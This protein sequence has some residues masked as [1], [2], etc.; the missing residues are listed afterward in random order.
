MVVAHRPTAL[1]GAD[2]MHRR[3]TT[4]QHARV[5]G[6]AMIGPI[7]VRLRRWATV[8]SLRRRTDQPGRR[9]FTDHGA[10]LPGV[11]DGYRLELA[12]ACRTAIEAL[13][14]GGEVADAE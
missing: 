7:I 9:F 12:E 13:D 4:L 11:M 3:T 6:L 5:A 1:Q 10:R 8:R 2:D 14:R